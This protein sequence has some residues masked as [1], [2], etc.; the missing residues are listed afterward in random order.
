[1]GLLDDFNNN[2]KKF[3]KRILLTGYIKIFDKF[4][5]LSEIEYNFALNVYSEK[6]SKFYYLPFAMLTIF[7]IPQIL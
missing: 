3:L 4:F 7:G 5:F 1:M 2:K 6:K